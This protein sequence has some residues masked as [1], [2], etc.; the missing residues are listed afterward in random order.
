LNAFPLYVSKAYISSLY[1]KKLIHNFCT[2]RPFAGL[3]KRA[4]FGASLAGVKPLG[5]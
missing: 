3:P 5:G 4:Y 2:E 1:L